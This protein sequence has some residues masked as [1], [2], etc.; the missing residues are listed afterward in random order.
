MVAEKVYI[1]LRRHGLNLKTNPYRGRVVPELMARKI[2]SYRELI[3][4]PWR[5]VYL[6]Q[7]EKVW[8]L[9]LFDSR[10]DA[11]VFFEER[12]LSDI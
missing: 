2:D 7:G 11:D 8:V 9:A 5:I 1:K 3:V 6:I 10:R 4:S 12:G